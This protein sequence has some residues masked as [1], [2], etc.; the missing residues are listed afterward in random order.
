MDLFNLSR[1]ATWNF[2]DCVPLWK[3]SSKGG[4]IRLTLLSTFLVEAD[5]FGASTP[6]DIA[7]W[8]A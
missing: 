8:L 1:D 7:G 5:I 6:V 3:V 2:Q 4:T